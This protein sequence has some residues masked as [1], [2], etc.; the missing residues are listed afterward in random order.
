MKGHYTK[1][2]IKCSDCQQWGH[3]SKKSIY[4]KSADET[5]TVGTILADNSNGFVMSKLARITSMADIRLASV[6]NSK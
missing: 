5:E 6:G 3:G 2:C 1:K 4:C